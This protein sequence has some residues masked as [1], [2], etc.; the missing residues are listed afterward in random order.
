MFNLNFK[1]LLNYTQRHPRIRQAYH[2]FFKVRIFWRATS[3]IGYVCYLHCS[4][5]TFEAIGKH[6]LQ[7]DNINRNFTIHQAIATDYPAMVGEP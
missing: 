2:R 5:E 4:R 3:K 1:S 7:L 6:S